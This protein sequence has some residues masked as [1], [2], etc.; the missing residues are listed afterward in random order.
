M[1]TTVVSGVQYSGIWTMQQVNAAIAAGTWPV[2]GPRL[3]SWGFS[4]FGALG[5]GNT[6][7]YSSPKQ[8]GSLATWASVATSS[9]S[10]HVL[11]VKNDGTLWAWG[12]NYH[13]GLG[14]GTNLNYYSSPKQVGSLTSWLKIATLYAT[15]VAIKTDGTLWSW[16][17]NSYGQLGLG[18]RTAYSSPK[19]VGSLTNWS[20]I[21]GG[22]YSCIALKTD[23]TIWTW[24]YNVDGR[25]G[26][27]NTTNY[28][29]PK[30]IGSLTNWLKIFSGYA[31]GFGIKTDGALWA[32]GRNGVG[33]LGIGN[34]ANNSSPIQVGALT[35]WS[36]VASAAG[37]S[38]ANAFTLSTKTDG[39]L[40]AWGVNV[41]GQL[42]LGTSGAY[43]RYSS[44][45]QVGS[46]TTWS[47]V[48]AGSFSTFAITS[49]GALWAWG[50]GGVGQL[51]INNRI[52]YSSPKQVGS[53]TSWLTIA[54]GP[55][56]G[57]GIAS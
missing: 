33:Q 50:R 23:G 7:S 35:T 26:L 11:A 47:S 24:G 49:G 29:S 57:I 13:G 9:S 34:T 25:L 16:G 19:Q 32:W 55:Y 18:N 2:V 21:S 22:L 3:Y 30:Q 14:L 38:S 48:A 31:S 45:V 54:G 52:D 37:G 43:S 28:S 6:T 12:S 15:S 17:E 42:G 56:M 27:N 53:L 4:S 1:A 10:S 8:V 41:Y 40:W 51:G 39:T 46:L 44:P 5:L 36:S 20:N